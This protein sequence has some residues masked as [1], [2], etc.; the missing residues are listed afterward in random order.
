[1]ASGSDQHIELLQQFALLQ[2]T[3]ESKDITAAETVAQEMVEII[4][5]WRERLDT[6]NEEAQQRTEELLLERQELEASIC[7]LHEQLANSEGE[8]EALQ[9]QIDYLNRE[10]E[11]KEAAMKEKKRKEEENR[12]DLGLAIGLWFIPFAGLIAGKV[13]RWQNLIPSFPW[14]AP[15]C[16]VGSAI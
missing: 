11:E 12:G 2:E 1:M 3:L 14:I 13:A 6:E 7:A 15:G 4:Q 5:D 9:T 8:E 10:L 16:R